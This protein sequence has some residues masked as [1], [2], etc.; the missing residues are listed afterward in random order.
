MSYLDLG[1]VG[2]ITVIGFRKGLSLFYLQDGGATQVVMQAAS[3]K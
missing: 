1:Q 3:H 2:G